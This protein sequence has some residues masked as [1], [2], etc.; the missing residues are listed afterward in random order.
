MQLLEVLTMMGGAL[1]P[2]LPFCEPEVLGLHIIQLGFHLPRLVAASLS[3]LTL[4]VL[5]ASRNPHIV[6]KIKICGPSDA[7]FVNCNA[8]LC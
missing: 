8:I 4:H 7:I 2:T 1:L 5:I 6:Q 3:L